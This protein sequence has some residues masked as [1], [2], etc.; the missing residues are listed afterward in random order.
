MA[1]VS[2]G[3]YMNVTLLDNGLDES[4]LSYALVE[5]D[6]AAALTDAA[7]ILARLALVTQA[8][9][10]GYSIGERFIENAIAIPVSNVHVENR[11]AVVC[12][13][14]GNPLK[15]HTIFIPAPSPSIFASLSG[16]NADVIN[17]D[18]ADL[19]NYIDIWKVT[20]A[21]AKVSDGE[22]LQDGLGAIVKG[23]RTHRR[24]SAG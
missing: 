7:D 15:K 6:F 12:Q 11:A 21:I 20:G 13:I 19:Q 2:A 8:E 22:F 5:T 16:E 1:L 10:K 23:K 3:L 4:T 9:I 14:N 17:T 24:S 18:H